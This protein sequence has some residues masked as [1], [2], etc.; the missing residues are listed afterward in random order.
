MSGLAYFGMV[1]DAEKINQIGTWLMVTAFPL[2]MLGAH[3]LDKIKEVKED[4]DNS[5]NIQN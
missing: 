3:A 5:I 4:K 2:I 1:E